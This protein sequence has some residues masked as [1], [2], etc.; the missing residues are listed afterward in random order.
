MAAVAALHMKSTEVS[1]VCLQLIAV[2]TTLRLW[3]VCY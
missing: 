2:F 3:W 1:D